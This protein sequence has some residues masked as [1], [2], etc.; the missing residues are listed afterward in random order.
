MTNPASRAD[1]PLISVY[2]RPKFFH[3]HSATIAAAAC[4]Y[5]GCFTD[6]RNF[7]SLMVFDLFSNSVGKTNGGTAIAGVFQLFCMLA[8]CNAD[9]FLR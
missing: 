5:I 7:S 1:S 3:N 2:P 9:C 8:N 6:S 4:L